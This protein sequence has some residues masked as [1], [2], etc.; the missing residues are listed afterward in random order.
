MCDSTGAKQRKIQKFGLPN[1]QIICSINRIK[2]VSFY[3]F[4]VLT[5]VPHEVF[6]Y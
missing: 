4:S 6:L 2:I 1:G 5:E 3:Y